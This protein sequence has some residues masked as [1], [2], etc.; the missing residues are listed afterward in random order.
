MTAGYIVRVKTTNDSPL[1]QTSRR[2][3][4]ETLSREIHYLGKLLGETIREQAGE[5]L[6]ALEEEIRLDARP[7][8]RGE[9]SI[10]PY[11]FPADGSGALA[12]SYPGTD[13]PLRS[14]LR[15]GSW[16]GGDQDGNPNVTTEVTARTLTR[17]RP[18]AAGPWVGEGGWLPSPSFPFRLNPYRWDCA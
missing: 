14:F 11:R 16:I 4:S 13:F 9:G 2:R 15:F 7:R 6:Y 8:R 3:T 1:P 12:R 17:M 10:V 18:A 5:R